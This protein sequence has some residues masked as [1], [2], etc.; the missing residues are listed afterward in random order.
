MIPKKEKTGKRQIH[1]GKKIQQ[2]HYLQLG[3]KKEK[4]KKREKDQ[5]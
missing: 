2:E 1:I 4:K 3:K 5:L